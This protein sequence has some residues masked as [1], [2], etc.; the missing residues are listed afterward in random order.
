MRAA[1]KEL[2]KLIAEHCEDESR[3]QELFQR[4]P[5]ILGG[6]HTK[7]DRHTHLDDRNIP[8]YT[9]V[10]ASDGFRDIFEIEQPFMP[11]FRKDGGFTAAFNDA[12][13]QTERYLTFTRRQRDYLRAEK[14]LY[15]ENPRCFL[16]VGQSLSHGELQA[17]RDREALNP[18]ITVLTYEQVLAMANAFLDLLKA[19]STAQTG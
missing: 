7:I 14:G 13:Q 5:W 11:C 4:Y 1:I 19:A 8:D 3:Y 2:E 16:I 12:W 18:A 6:Q 9:G 10:R 17:I 15:F